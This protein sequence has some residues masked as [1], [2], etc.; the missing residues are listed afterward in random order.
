MQKILAKR[1]RLVPPSLSDADARE[2]AGV[3][4]SGEGLAMPIRPGLRPL[5][6]PH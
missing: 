6:P 1:E 2:T 4:I 5:Y 3:M